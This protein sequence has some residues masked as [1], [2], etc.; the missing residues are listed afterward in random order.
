MTEQD[1]PAAPEGPILAWQAPESPPSLPPGAYRP[2]L[3]IGSVLTETFA[4]YAADPLRIFGIAVVPGIAS[5]ASSLVAG[6]QPTDL[7][8]LGAYLSTTLVLTLVV[9]AVS[10][11]GT[12]IT[13]ALLEG[14]PGGDLGAAARWGISRVGW[15]L[16]TGIAVGLA[17][18]A[19]ALVIV[20]VVFAL[21]TTSVLAAVVVG[22]VA[23]LVLVCVSARL[24]P[25]FTAV[26]VDRLNVGQ[27]IRLAWQVT[28]P[29]GVW[30]RILGSLLV[31]GLVIGPAALLASGLTLFNAV[32]GAVAT[33]LSALIL[34]FV[35]PFSTILQYS[36]Y[37]RLVG[38]PVQ[39]GMPPGEPE[40][41][42]PAPDAMPAAVPPHA[43][44]AP[45][46][47]GRAR[48]LL[49]ATI[50]LGVVGL[51]A[52]PFAFGALMA[53]QLSVPGR[54]FPGN[55]PAGSVVFGP[56]GNLQTCTVN[57]QTTTAAPFSPIVFM[58]HFRRPATPL[59]V[60]R[61]R[62]SVDGTEIVNEVENRGSFEC[63]GIS[64]AETDIGAGHYEFR[65]FL[66]DE[67]TAE[68]LLTVQ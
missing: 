67:L 32:P 55:V 29:A 59:D 17:A 15:L 11:L 44:A 61:M 58:G 40:A 46:F 37:R 30:L 48:A 56:T 21:G 41:I 26:V 52:A 16:V 50:V 24:A 38:P 6:R 34:I 1:A 43:S 51:V 20:I 47:G 27:A 2:G 13:I 57:N 60:V 10:L 31:I 35:T 45:P 64:T 39:A 68:G 49:G 7:A 66:N 14:G 53:R 19:V 22:T 12:S 18:V 8:G 9:A 3:S 54:S 36:I 4:R 62:V 42:P 23:V 33:G 5:A 63:L 25:A 28:R 65:M